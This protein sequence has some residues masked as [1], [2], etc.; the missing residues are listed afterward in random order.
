MRSDTTPGA[1]TPPYGKGETRDEQSSNASIAIQKWVNRLEL[2]VREAR[3]DQDRKTMVLVE[4]SLEIIERM[5][6]SVRGWRHKWRVRAARDA[7]ISSGR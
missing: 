3:I 2:R 6:H 1:A 7:P 4:E 5:S